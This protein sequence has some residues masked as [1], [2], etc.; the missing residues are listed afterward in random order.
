MLSTSTVLIPACRT[1][2]DE[3]LHAALPEF[4]ATYQMLPPCIMKPKQLWS[5]KQVL[6]AVHL[7]HGHVWVGLC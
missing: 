2:Y 5:G 6:S 4:P 3:L 1:M 7:L